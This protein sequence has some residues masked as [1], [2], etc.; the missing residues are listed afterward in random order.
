MFNI[1]P[2]IEYLLGEKKKFYRII[3]YLFYMA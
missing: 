3:I 1:K 2:E